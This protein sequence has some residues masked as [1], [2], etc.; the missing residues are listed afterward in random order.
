MILH[1]EGDTSDYAL[2]KILKSTGV[3]VFK[4]PATSNL[5][6]SS[7][8]R[9]TEQTWQHVAVILSAGANIEFVLDAASSSHAATMFSSPVSAT[10][11]IGF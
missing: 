1:H 4:S 10:L 9:I 8:L 11:H 5:E 3:L 2:F 7:S 6:L